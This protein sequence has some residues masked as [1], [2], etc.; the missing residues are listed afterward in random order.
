M[1]TLVLTL[2]LTLIAIGLAA[3]NDAEQDVF[4]RESQKVKDTAPGEARLVSSVAP[5]RFGNGMEARW[6]FAFPGPEQEARGAFAK[7]APPHYS[8][9]TTGHADVVYTR[10]EGN[11]S[12]AITYKFTPAG[13]KSTTVTVVLTAMPD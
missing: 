12:Y 10:S 8:A 11:D 9:L 6:E 7:L 2:A 4:G 3:C 5:H 13:P 1:K